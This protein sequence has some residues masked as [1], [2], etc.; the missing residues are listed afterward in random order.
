MI[1]TSTTHVFFT[2]KVAIGPLSFN[3]RSNYLDEQWPQ[4][5]TSSANLHR[6]YLINYF[7]IIN[8]VY[9]ERVCVNY[10]LITCLDNYDEVGSL[11]LIEGASF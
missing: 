6:I 1:V 7:I 10:T 4:N 8:Y 9:R 2:G 3:R 5:R 11:D